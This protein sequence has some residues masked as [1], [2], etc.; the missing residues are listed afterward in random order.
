[1]SVQRL[2]LPIEG[3][4]CASCAVRVEKKLNKLEGVAATVNYATE[5]A[6]VEFEAGSVSP[7]QLVAAVEAAGYKAA[8]PSDEA[9]DETQEDPAASLRRRLLISAALTLPVLAARDDPAA[10][11]RRLAVA[12]ARSSQR[13]SSS[14]AAGRSTARRTSTPATAPRRWTR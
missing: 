14:G 5:R 13:L 12:V 4:T 8:L 10:P 2:E 1:M 3:M 6:S 11:V 7:E 9:A